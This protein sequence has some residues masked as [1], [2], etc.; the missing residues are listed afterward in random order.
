MDVNGQCACIVNSTLS[1]VSE[2][3]WLASQFATLTC[4]GCN[5]K[6]NLFS[7]FHAEIATQL[8]H[9]NLRTLYTLNIIL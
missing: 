1:S 7:E 4:L 8:C 6:L 3:A 9:I 5:A 2:I